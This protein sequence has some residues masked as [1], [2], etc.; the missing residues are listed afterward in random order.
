MSLGLI[1]AIASPNEAMQAFLSELSG[2]NQPQPRSNKEGT[3]PNE[4]TTPGA[5]DKAASEVTQ[6]AVKAERARVSGIQQCEEAKGREA[7][8]NHLAFN[9]GMSVEE[10]KGILANAPKAEAAATGNAFQQAMD[11]GAHPNVGAGGNSGAP[12]NAAA[13]ILAAAKA[14]GVRSF[15]FGEQS[16]A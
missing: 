3:M 4:A 9:T 15:V 6:E 14:A 11:N 2:S 5:N 16:K 1:D 13:E 10:A 12:E 7:L 8:A